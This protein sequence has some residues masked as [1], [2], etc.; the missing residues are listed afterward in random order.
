[1]K[2][3]TF[4]IENNVH[5]VTDNI[6]VML[7]CMEVELFE[8]HPTVTFKQPGITITLYF[9]FQKQRDRFMKVLKE[10]SYIGISTNEELE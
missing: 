3:N 8:D 7:K 9:G 4:S 6:Q 10:V 5:R 2:N 1:M